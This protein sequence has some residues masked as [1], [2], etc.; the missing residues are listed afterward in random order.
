[1]ATPLFGQNQLGLHTGHYS[2]TAGLSANPAAFQASPYQWDVT[3]LSGGTF[4][5]NDYLQIENTSVFNLIFK[6]IALVDGTFDEGLATSEN[7]KIYRF[8]DATKP[9][10]NAVNSFAGAPA[11]AKRLNKKWSFGFYAKARLAFNANFVHPMWSY[12]QLNDWDYGQTKTSDPIWVTGMMWTEFALN[13][14]TTKTINGLNVSMGVNAKY[15]MGNDGLYA[16]VPNAT[17]ITLYPQ[18]YEV[19]AQIAHYGFTNLD[20]GFSF[21]R[22]GNGLGA[23]IG[24]IIENKTNENE[25]GKWRTSISIIDIGWVTFNNNAQNHTTTA[26]NNSQLNRASLNTITSLNEF[27]QTISSEVMGSPTASLVGNRFTILTPTALLVGIDY[28]MSKNLYAQFE[29]SRHLILHPQQLQ[30][31]NYITISS[32]YQTSWFEF[33]VPLILYNDVDLRA[34]LWLRMGPLTVGSDN[35]TTLFIPQ[36]RLTGTDIYFALRIN[37]FTFAK[38]RNKKNSPE[39]CYW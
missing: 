31:D 3:L 18:D 25:R 22:K 37:D 29:I 15:L 33:G 4:V 27:A 35:F 20:E 2:G 19:D 8:I 11:F 39:D 10:H 1:M 32:R 14:A 38:N 23:D 26:T 28:K 24:I 21:A 5:E 17:D 9:M 34:G 7:Q 30:R 13:V 16:F 12:P 36:Q 6:D